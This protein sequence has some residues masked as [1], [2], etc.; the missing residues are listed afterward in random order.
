MITIHTPQL[1]ENEKSRL[2]TIIEVDG[3]TKTVWFEVDKKYGKYLCYE[4]CDAFLVGLLHYA[5][6]NDHDIRCLSPL[7]ED[8]YYQIDTYIINALNKGNK[9]FFRKIK[10]FADIEPNVENAGAVGTGISCGIDSLH[11]ITNHTDIRFKHHNITHLTLFNVGIYDEGVK[12]EELFKKRVER[13]EVFCS[14]Y[15]FEF[16]KVDSNFMAE[17]IQ[18]NLLVHTYRDCS[19]V[20]ALQK[21]FAYYYYSSGY[22]FFEFSLNNIEKDSALYD[23]FLLD[24]FS[25]SK[26]KFYSEGATKSRIE[27][28]VVVADYKPSYKYLNVCNEESE[29]CGKCEKC[30]R[31]ML[32]LE[33]IGKLENY[34][35]VF[36]IQNFKNNR[37][38]V[39]RTIYREHLYNNLSYKEIY[40][41]YH[42]EISLKIKLYELVKKRGRISYNYLSNSKIGI[43]IIRFYQ[44]H[45]KKNHSKNHL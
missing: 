4:R 15:N 28:T 6:C 29:N 40:P 24:M 34:K 41:F 9:Q 26:L 18:D 44:K 17:F 33:M 38:N 36:D 25:S 1:V 21:L 8:L 45:I 30:I 23:L 13:A 10:I 7:S 2:Q 14:E 22:T 20:L 3:Q 43:P 35:E 37:V 32:I 39:L 5:I 16:I 31:T 42:K 11:T 12:A 27:K 19:F